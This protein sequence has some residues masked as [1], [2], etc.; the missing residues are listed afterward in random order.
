MHP[1]SST[2]LRRLQQRKQG[3]ATDPQTA[4][5]RTDNETNVNMSSGAKDEVKRKRK[6]LTQPQ[7]VRGREMDRLCRLPVAAYLSSIL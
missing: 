6:K 1:S 4:R 7:S 2:S 5:T 3:A